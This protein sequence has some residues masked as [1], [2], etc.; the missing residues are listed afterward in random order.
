[1][2]GGVDVLERGLRQLAWTAVYLRL[3]QKK[4][5]FGVIITNFPRKKHMTAYVRNLSLIRKANTLGLTMPQ[6]FNDRWDE[7]K[8]KIL[9]LPEIGAKRLE[10]I[11]EAFSDPY[12]LE[13]RLERSR[14]F[15]DYHRQSK[16]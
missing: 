5:P 9:T 8:E 13:K 3:Q 11:R 10:M 16:N 7:N 12:N 15:S 6:R 4:V 1:M 2:R 14:W